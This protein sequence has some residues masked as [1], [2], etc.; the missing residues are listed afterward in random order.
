[1]PPALSPEPPPFSEPS[2]EP[3]PSALPRASRSRATRSCS[4]LSVWSKSPSE[5]SSALSPASRRSSEVLA[6]SGP[7]GLALP[8]SLS[9]PPL[10]ELPEPA[11]LSPLPSL[12]SPDSPGRPAEGLAVGSPGIP[13]MPGIPLVP[14]GIPVELPPGIPPGMPPGIPPGMPP[15][16]PPP[17]PPGIPPGLGMPPPPPPVDAQPA[18][19]AAAAAR[20]IRSGGMRMRT[21]SRF[22]LVGPGRRLTG[23]R[24][25]AA[26]LVGHAVA[27]RGLDSRD[28]RQ[29][30]Y[31][32]H[33]GGS[34]SDIGADATRRL[35]LFQIP[36]GS[37]VGGLL[38]PPAE[39]DAAG[40]AGRRT[41]GQAAAAIGL[42]R[43]A[44]QP[45]YI[46]HAAFRD[47]LGHAGARQQ[48][49]HGLGLARRRARLEPR[50]HAVH[51]LIVV[52][53]L[54]I[55]A[56][57][58]IGAHAIHELVFGTGAFDLRFGQDDHAFALADGSGHLAGFL[59]ARLHAAG[60]QYESQA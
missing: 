45:D 40:T 19:R 5:S 11:L 52:V 24:E 2:S 22:R 10:S 44:I 60:E 23:S 29:R 14:P 54:E 33:D 18:S 50:E 41:A 21:S 27:C 15:G 1:M 36:D 38:L 37:L 42:A 8:A 25:K 56:V 30:N 12:P 6:P 55:L 7:S 58:E 39:A 34:S 47:L 28:E 48:R 53:D 20:G 43:A 4:F 32:S 16:E 46:T 31:G 35:G 51:E 59:D 57:L 3:S 9:P 26:Q 49:T 13:G 17:E